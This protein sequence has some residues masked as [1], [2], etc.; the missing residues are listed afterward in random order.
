ML[1]GDQREYGALAETTE[2]LTSEI[3]AYIMTG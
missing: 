1:G 3:Q 2:V